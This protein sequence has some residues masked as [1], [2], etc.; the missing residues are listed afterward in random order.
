MESQFF[1]R[2]P[3]PDAQGMN[4]PA[5]Q[6]RHRRVDQ[7]MTLEG[8]LTDERGGND[9]DGEVAALARAGVAGVSGAVV[10]DGQAFGGQRGAQPLLDQG[11]AVA[12]AGSTLRN[13]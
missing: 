11:D 8:S 6:I 10:H 9:V 12:H 5:Q 7:T 4:V 1:L 2:R 13:G 3:R